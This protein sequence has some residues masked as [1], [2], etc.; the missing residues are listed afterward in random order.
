MA[1]APFPGTWPGLAAFT[2]NSDFVLDSSGNIWLVGESTA[3]GAGVF[4]STNQGIS[5]TL[6]GTI[7]GVTSS[8]VDF[9]PAVAIDSS[10]NLHFIGQ[11]QAEN[12]SVSLVKYEWNTGTSTLTGPFTPLTGGLIGSDYDIVSLANGN[13]YLAV[14]FISGSQEAIQGIELNPTGTAVY[15]DILVSQAFATGNRYGSVS[16]YTPDGVAVEIYLESHP[17]IY[18]PQGLTSTISLITRTAP[19][20]LSTATPLTTL[21]IMYIDPDLT[22]LGNGADR[23]LSLGYYTQ[24]GSQLVGNI[25]LGALLSS[26]GTWS[27]RSFSGTPV[28]SLIQPTLSIFASGLVL[29]FITQNFSAS[30]APGDAPIGLFTLLPATWTLIA[31][32]DFPYQA[33]ASWL[34]GSRSMLPSGMPWGFLG[35]Q[36]NGGAARFYTGFNPPPTVVLTPNTLTALRGTTYEFDASGSFSPNLDVLHFA[37]EI[38]DPTGQAIFTPEGEQ[39]T[40]LLPKSAGPDAFTITITVSVTAF[41]ANGD[42]LHSA[43]TQSC[44]VS[45][46]LVEPPV[47]S[48]ASAI[49]VAR[50]TTVNFT[51]TVTDAAGYTLA[52]EWSQVSGT[53]LDVLS[54]PSAETLT[55]TTNGAAVAGESVEFQ[56][57]ATDGM[58]AAVTGTF[59]FNIAARVADPETLSWFRTTWPGTISQR[60]TSNAWPAGTNQNEITNF[61]TGK[62]GC[63]VSGNNVFILVSPFSVL[64]SVAQGINSSLATYHVLLPN[65]NDTVLDA[66]HSDYDATVVLTAGGLI[67][68]FAPNAALTDTDNATATLT[69]SSYTA[70]SYTSLMVTPSHGGVR[71]FVL[72]GSPGVF[73]LEVNT[74]SLAVT[75][76]LEISLASGFL[77]GADNVDFVRLSDVESLRTGEILV[78]TSDSNGNTFETLVNLATRSIAG[79]WDSSSL[80]NPDITTGEL[81]FMPVDSYTGKPLP[82]VLETPTPIAGGYTLN[83]T[84]TRPDLVTGYYIFAAQGSGAFTLYQTVNSGLITTLT[85][86]GFPKSTTWSFYVQAQS[87]DGPSPN[88]NAVQISF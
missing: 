70:N 30:P 19:D 13:C 24:Q 61:A 60:N 82:P 72:F 27:F 86:T 12:G 48:S 42:Q 58:N 5:F 28:A 50:N 85:L 33:T 78:G 75:S 23:Y 9:D 51:P 66:E 63:L 1:S 2:G 73:L 55:F 64:V 68:Q 14:C 76:F 44:S 7:T 84:Q 62:R 8:G 3:S 40:L 67:Q 83:W 41:D 56:L 10:D 45:Y 16:L 4:K 79:T 59:T 38:T 46:P 31:R 81:L 6:A 47:I 88:S 54:D 53:T 18:S 39:A 52:F 17:K 87:N 71:V 34:R 57:S 77:Y 25:L 26:G 35:Q 74:A 80:T 69:L 29:A 11:V 20:T 43:V 36:A 22:V 37:W 65:T 32:T 21:P 49:A 15:Q